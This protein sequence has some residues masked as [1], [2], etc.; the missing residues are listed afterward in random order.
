[1]C[2]RMC[3]GSSKV[4]GFPKSNLDRHAR[5]GY[6]KSFTDTS[7]QLLLSAQEE[8]PESRSRLSLRLPAVPPIPPLGSPVEP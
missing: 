3:I 8:I 6:T 4:W 5:Q 2:L 7:I 1:M